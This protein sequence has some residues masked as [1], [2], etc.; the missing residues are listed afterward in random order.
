MISVIVPTY[1]EEK[2]LASCLESVREQPEACEL[3]VADGGSFDRTL[4]IAQHYTDL[5][6][7]SETPGLAGQLNAGAAIAKGSILLFLHAD[8]LLSPGCFSRLT[9]LPPGVNG[10]AFTMR[11]AGKRLF[12]RVLSAGGNIYCRLTRTYF[13]DRGIF[14]RADAFRKLGGFTHLP[15]MTDVDFSRRLKT[16]GNTVLLPGPVITS[17]RKFDDE[18]AWRTLYLII[19]ALVAFR[20]NADLQKVKDKYYS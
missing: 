18:S 7:K 8:S 12:Y 10:G 20:L 3:I 19:Y 13:G 2:L 11:V 15:I 9:S 6:I 17:S 14:V 1:N 4:E 5:I 16:I